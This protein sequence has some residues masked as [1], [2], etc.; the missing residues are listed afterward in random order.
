MPEHTHR[1]TLHAEPG[2]T[3]LQKALAEVS[4]K[5]FHLT[6]V[7]LLIP[8]PPLDRAYAPTALVPMVGDRI[9]QNVH[10]LP[11]EMKGVALC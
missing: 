2:V 4:I 11:T 1:T 3:K 9:R 7:I 8:P 10:H 5:Y 6:L